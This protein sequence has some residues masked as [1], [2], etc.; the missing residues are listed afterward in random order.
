[1]VLTSFLF[2]LVPFEVD[3]YA[4]PVGARHGFLG[5]GVQFHSN[6]LYHQGPPQ[7]DSV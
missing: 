7:K 1:M 4:Y 2:L 5:S 6:S 3:V